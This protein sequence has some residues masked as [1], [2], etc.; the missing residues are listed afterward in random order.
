[1]FVS[2]YGH[3]Q[4]QG[5]GIYDILVDLPHPFQYLLYVALR[6]QLCIVPLVDAGTDG[7]FQFR[8]LFRS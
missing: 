7:A 4:R 5:R 6:E 2:L 8:P 1:V 3:V